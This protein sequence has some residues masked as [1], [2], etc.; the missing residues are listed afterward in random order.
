MSANTTDIALSIRM[1]SWECFYSVVLPAAL[2]AFHR[3]LAAAA[4]FALDATLI[5]RLGLRPDLASSNPLFFID[6]P[7]VSI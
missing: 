4:I 6:N 3:A 1:E 7:P 2:A 5:F